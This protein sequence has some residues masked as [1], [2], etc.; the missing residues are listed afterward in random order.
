MRSLQSIAV[1][2]VALL[3]S[4]AALAVNVNFLSDDDGA[5]TA[6]NA[7]TSNIDCIA[8]GVCDV[9]PGRYRLI[10][11][12]DFH[13]VYIT[14]NNDGTVRYTYDGGNPFPYAEPATTDPVDPVDPVD[15]IHPTTQYRIESVVVVATCR[16]AEPGRPKELGTPN[17]TARCPDSYAVTGGNCR[18]ITEGARTLNPDGNSSTFT[19]IRQP[20]VETPIDGGYQCDYDTGIKYTASD[21]IFNNQQGTTI[22]A[23]AI[24]ATVVSQ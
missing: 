24:C 21:F 20:L 7:S 12:D 5:Y 15:P 1:A 17:C 2:S 9:D 18:G 3:G 11:F 10:G 13:S 14:V 8:P 22:T 6:R 4:T 19:D 16:V 23:T